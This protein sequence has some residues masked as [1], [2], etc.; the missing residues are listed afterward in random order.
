MASGEG[1]LRGWEGN[2]LFTIFKMLYMYVY[3]IYSKNELNL[4]EQVN[5]RERGLGSDFNRPVFPIWPP[6]QISSFPNQTKV[7][8]SISPSS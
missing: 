2:V 1:E 8:R 7:S 5:Q 6:Y 3:I 4:T